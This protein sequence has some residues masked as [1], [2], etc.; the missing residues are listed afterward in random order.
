MAPA[1]PQVPELE[2]GCHRRAGTRHTR[3]SAMLSPRAQG[4][5]WHRPCVAKMEGRQTQHYCW[6]DIASLVLIMKLETI[7]RKAANTTACRPKGSKYVLGLSLVG[8]QQ[9]LRK[10]V[11]WPETLKWVLGTGA[12]ANENTQPGF[13]SSEGSASERGEWSSVTARCS[14]FS[15]LK[16][17]S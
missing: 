1:G 11:D 7:F 12:G 17:P 14:E 6:L 3:Q 5:D 8:R 10:P 9:P 4:R 13:R 16:S 2:E 15:A